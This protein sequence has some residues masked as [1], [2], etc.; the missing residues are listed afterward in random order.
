MKTPIFNKQEQH[1]WNTQRSIEE[2]RNFVIGKLTP[3]SE[4]DLE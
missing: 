1:S 2:L 3:L 4:I